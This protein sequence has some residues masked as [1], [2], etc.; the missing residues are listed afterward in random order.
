MIY[1]LSKFRD[2]VTSIHVLDGDR[3]FIK[4]IPFDLVNTDYKEYLVWVAKGNQPEEAE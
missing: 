1:K 2:E 3:R 4:A